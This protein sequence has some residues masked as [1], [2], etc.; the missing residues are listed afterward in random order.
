MIKLKTLLPEYITE[1]VS[2]LAKYL[3]S[4]EE[5]KKVELAFQFPEYIF[6]FTDADNAGNEEAA[7]IVDELFKKNRPKFD[8]YADFVYKMYIR[9]G[10]NDEFFHTP[11]YPSW[12]YMAYQ[13][14]LKNQWLI[15]FSDN[16]LDIWRDQQFKF[17]YDD[18]TTL[19]LT[20]YLSKSTKKYGGYNFAYDIKDYLK[21]G[22][23]SFGG[24]GWKYG[25]EAVV[26]RASGI[27]VWHHG[28]EEPQVIFY[29][30]TARDM[31]H[32]EQTDPGPW[33]ITN[34]KTGKNIYIGEI[35]DVVRW[36]INNFNQYKGVLLP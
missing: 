32:I 10:G 34:S 5:D 6:Q 17:G 1:P 8:E 15:H 13:G 33:G 25:S 27:K 18:Y 23:S 2:A 35:G 31:V 28:D 11:G 19:G 30:N 7:D 12:N 14:M 16:A 29:G 9:S 21:Y 26:F 20:T 4:S 3:Q 36:A 24:G 22:R